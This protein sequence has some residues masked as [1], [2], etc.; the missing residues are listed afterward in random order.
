MIAAV[1][2]LMALV[3]RRELCSKASGA[4]DGHKYSQIDHAT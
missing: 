3:P 4:V 1:I 2:N